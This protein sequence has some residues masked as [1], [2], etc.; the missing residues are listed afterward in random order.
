[1]SGEEDE[2]S[3]SGGE[4][5]DVT[6]RKPLIVSGTPTPFG[7]EDYGLTPENEDG[8]VDTQAGSHP[9][10]LTSTLGLNQA[11]EEGNLQFGMLP[12]VPALAKD[13]HIKLPPGLIG[14]PTPFP[15]CTDLEFD[16][17]G[18]ELI[19]GCPANTAVGVAMVTVSEPALKGAFT[20][21]VPLFNLTPQVGEPARFGFEVEGVSAYPR[22]VGSHR[23]RLRRD[24]QRQQHHTGGLVPHR[25]G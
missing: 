23:R 25:V 9:F 13:L 16:M 14:N 3:I 20:A 4:A 1:M 7:V 6:I 12:S 18:H 10:Q 11:V 8:S 5:P 19:N 21:P 22:H 17:V 24:G 2:V 15:Q